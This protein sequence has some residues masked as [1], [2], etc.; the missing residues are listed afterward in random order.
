[1]E[2]AGERLDSDKDVGSTV[3]AR[4][5]GLGFLLF[6]CFFSWSNVMVFSTF[7]VQISDVLLYLDTPHLGFSK[8]HLLVESSTDI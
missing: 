6:F 1:M 8:A 7:H 2:T 5:S 3:A 4:E